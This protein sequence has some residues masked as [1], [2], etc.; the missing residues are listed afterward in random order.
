MDIG[1]V[2]THGNLVDVNV[3]M[4]TA[5]KL[6]THED[7]GLGQT[8]ISSAFS[9]GKKT[10][11]PAEVIAE[12]KALDNKARSILNNHSFKFTFGG[13][14]FVPKKRFMDFVVEMDEVIK[15][16]NAK[17]DDLSKN[18][19]VYRQD[20]RSEYV[21][22]SH[23]A[24][25]RA[26]SL[27]VGLDITE[28]EFVNNFLERIEQSYPKAEDIRG[29]FHMEYSVFQVALP[30]LSNASYEDLLDESGKVKMME[31]AYR[32]SLYN[33]VNNFVESCTDEM[34]DKATSVLNRLSESLGSDRSITERTLN[35]TR[36]MIEEYEKMDFVGD[37]LFLEHLNMFKIKC[38]DC[39]NSKTINTSSVVK[40]TIIRELKTIL[41]VA[42]DR[43]AIEALAHNYRMKIGL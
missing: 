34:R 11:I 26:T 1:K 7:L 19:M 35:T 14:R 22:A 38:L 33:K 40:G 29:K 25:A 13:A 4:W 27:C 43:S 17:A 5:T 23:E 10:L 9:L 21:K 42:Q 20:M 39:Y 41:K 12:L 6:L 2:F 8:D 16:F 36:K 37:N 31:D 24:F 18:Y 15:Q 28:D 30:D 32:K 3:S